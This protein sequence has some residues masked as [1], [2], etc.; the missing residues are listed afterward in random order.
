MAGLCQKFLSRS[1]ID[2][3]G[4]HDRIVNP[5]EAM[6]NTVR[7]SNPG[8]LRSQT[9]AGETKP[10]GKRKPQSG[11]PLEHGHRIREANALCCHPFTVARMTKQNEEKKENGA[12]QMVVPSNLLLAG[13]VFHRVFARNVSIEN[14]H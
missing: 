8:V 9:D 1:P 4:D 12:A 11:S 14:E 10:S 2:C 6:L 13:I 7:S 5:D 3:S